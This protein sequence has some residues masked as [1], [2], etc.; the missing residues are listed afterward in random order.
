MKTSNEVKMYMQMGKKR[1]SKKSNASKGILRKA[2]A[3]LISVF[4]FVGIIGLIC[5]LGGK[6]E[7]QFVKVTRNGTVIG[8]Y[9]LYKEAVIT[10]E[11]D[12][13]ENTLTIKNGKADMSDA[14]CPDKIC[15]SHKPIS[16]TGES[17][18]CLPHKIVVE[19][20]SDNSEKE[21]HT[22]FDVITN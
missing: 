3:I 20:I 21:E 18:V 7:G 15:V 9:S 6:Q 1:A 19:I 10:I 12:G 11:G 8:K 13:G 4:L 22:G 5:Y 17:I 14:D 2:D 16:K